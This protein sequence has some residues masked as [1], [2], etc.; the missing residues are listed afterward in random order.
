MTSIFVF[1]LDTYKKVLCI[2]RMEDVPSIGERHL[3]LPWAAFRI[4]L[5]RTMRIPVDV[6]KE[7]VLWI[8]L[9]TWSVCIP[10]FHPTCAN[11]VSCTVSRIYMSVCGFLLMILKA[12]SL[13]LLPVVD[14]SGFCHGGAA[15]QHHDPHTPTQMDVKDPITPKKIFLCFGVQSNTMGR[16]PQFW[17]RLKAKNS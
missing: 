8:L 3:G 1:L 14:T 7:K 10:T 6:Y 17:S 5:A 15:K 9:L 16:G 4:Y 12:E 11:D 13:P 2:I